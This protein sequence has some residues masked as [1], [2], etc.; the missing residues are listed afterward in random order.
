MRHALAMVSVSLALAASLAA[1]SKEESTAPAATSAPAATVTVGEW[2]PQTTAVGAPV[3]VQADGSSAIWIQAT[4]VAQ[5]A[6]TRVTF[7]S[8]A[9][10]NVVVAEKLVT[11]KVPKQVI[12]Q[13]GSYPV[14]IEEPS[15]RKT[16]VG[17]F[18][19]VGSGK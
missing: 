5:D 3:N 16:T 1:C 15:G 2:G 9:G 17:N 12:D 14:V 6:A 8:N 19:V 13:A 10:E 11:V 4:G 7:G 18:E